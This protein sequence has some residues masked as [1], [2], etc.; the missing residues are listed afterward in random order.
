MAAV[1]A[2][3]GPALVSAF[4]PVGLHAAQLHEP[5]VSAINSSLKV[6]GEQPLVISLSCSLVHPLESL[7]RTNAL[8]LSVG[9]SSLRVTCDVWSSAVEA[10]TLAG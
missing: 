1:G 10:V 8:S 6:L 3:P 2:A 7:L 5:S 4:V 9:I